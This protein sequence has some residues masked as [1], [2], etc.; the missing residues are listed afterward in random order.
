MRTGIQ[1]MNY[2]HI[3]TINIIVDKIIIAYVFWCQRCFIY[4]L[5]KNIDKM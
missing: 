2:A 3:N 5:I 1:Y 4:V